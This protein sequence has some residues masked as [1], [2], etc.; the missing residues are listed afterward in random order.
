MVHSRSIVLGVGQT[1]MRRPMMRQTRYYHVRCWF[2][3]ATC[4]E[5]HRICQSIRL[6]MQHKALLPLRHIRHAYAQ[7]YPHDSM[8]SPMMVFGA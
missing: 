6:L 2:E 1:M 5:T 7:L 3:K 4:L 8:I